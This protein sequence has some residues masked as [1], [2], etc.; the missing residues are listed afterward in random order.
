MIRLDTR[1]AP[2]YSYGM[3]ETQEGAYP[4]SGIFW[5]RLSPEM[6]SEVDEWIGANS[7]DDVKRIDRSSAMRAL[8]AK[9]LAD[10]NRVRKDR[11]R[12]R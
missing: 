12:K 10:W 1:H 8:I 9:G 2:L 5:L 6:V 7:T 3:A 11:K 4:K